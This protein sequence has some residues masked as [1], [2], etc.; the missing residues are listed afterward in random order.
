MEEIKIS[1]KLS[2]KLGEDRVSEI[3]EL[4]SLVNFKSLLADMMAANKCSDIVRDSVLGKLE[5]LTEVLVKITKINGMH[6]S[7]DAKKEKIEKELAGLNLETFKKELVDEICATEKTLKTKAKDMAMKIKTA[8]SEK[9]QS[10]KQV[11]NSNI[12]TVSEKLKAAKEKESLLKRKAKNKGEEFEEKAPEIYP[13]EEKIE[14]PEK[15]LE[16]KLDETIE[17]RKK[18]KEE[19]RG[20]EDDL[21]MASDMERQGLAIY[22][23]LG[24]FNTFRKLWEHRKDDPNKK[25]GFFS[26]AKAAYKLSSQNKETARELGVEEN[27]EASYNEQVE[28][29]NEIKR[30]EKS[31]QQLTREM[32]DIERAIIRE[33]GQCLDFCKDALEDALE[34]KEVTPSRLTILTEKI[35][36]F[37]KGLGEKPKQ[38]KK[39]ID[40]K[41]STLMEHTIDPLVDAILGN[42]EE[43]LKELK[44]KAED[45][46]IKADMAKIDLETADFKVKGKEFLYKEAESEL[47]YIDKDTELEDKV[48]ARIIK[49]VRKGELALANSR[50]KKKSK[51]FA[52]AE[53][54]VEKIETKIQ[55]A[56]ARVKED[57]ERLER[58]DA[59]RHARGEG[60]DR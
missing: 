17:K 46:S 39:S 37:G 25:R 26:I 4:G 13:E 33:S 14:E 10:V 43:D 60:M 9:V 18:V 6:I 38:W 3:S 49:G 45:L 1:K 56:E 7:N 11:I 12:Q 34:P 50:Y 31:Y 40:S 51:A 54:K 27:I 15:S 32:R 20:L 16:E 22:K 29:S 53:K 2:E 47:S 24:F 30:L 59:R 48:A 44:D 5:T 57:K 58:R 55:K 41:I 52:R 42:P 19:I 23:N 28:I 21:E 35:A 36:N 8:A